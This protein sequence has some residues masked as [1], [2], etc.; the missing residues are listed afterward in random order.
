MP[1]LVVFNPP[2]WVKRMLPKGSKF[3]GQLSREVRKMHYRHADD[4]KLYVHEFDLKPGVSMFA[5]EGPSG[6]NAILIVGS[7]GQSLWEDF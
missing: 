4:G 6:E 5:V 1:Q 2:M 7:E 3:I